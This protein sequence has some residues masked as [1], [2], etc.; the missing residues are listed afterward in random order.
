MPGSHKGNFPCPAS[1][2]RGEQHQQFVKAIICKAGDAVIFTESLTHGTLPWTADHLRRSVLFKMSPAPLSFSS[3]YDAYVS[4]PK[5][6]D[7]TEAQRAVLERP[8][9]AGAHRPSAVTM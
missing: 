5:L 3:G 6:A 9:R 4:D 8:Y 2:R 1:L 7:L